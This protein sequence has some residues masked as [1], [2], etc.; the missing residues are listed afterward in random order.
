VSEHGIPR[1]SVVVVA[2]H[3]PESLHALL[4]GLRHPALDLIVVNVEDDPRIR[5]VPGARVLA[6]SKNVGYAAAVNAGVAAARGAVVAFCNDDLLAGADGVM[7][8]VEMVERGD[9]AVAVPRVLTPDGATEPTIAALPT[10]R[11]IALEWLCLPDRPLARLRTGRLVQ[12]WRRPQTVERIDAAAAVMVVASRQ[13]LQRMPL[14]DAYF[15]YWE[16]SDWF[17][18]LH[19]SGVPVAYVPSVT[20][21]HAAGRADVRSDKSALLAR[22]A[23]RCVRRTQGRTAAALAWPVVVLWQL[24][25]VVTSWSRPAARAMRPARRAGLRAALSAWR[26]I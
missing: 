3:R 12:K 1:A 13:L 24:R 6:M 9:A 14:P 26:E 25:L 21:T 19:R 22:N 18:Q 16:E 4:D 2:F 23:V 20:V 17:W 5:N 8:L 15:L 10:P 7:A 11:R